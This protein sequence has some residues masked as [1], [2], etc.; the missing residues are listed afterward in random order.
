MTSTPRWW[1]LLVFTSPV[2]FAFS[3][4]AAEWTVADGF[5]VTE[6]AVPGL[7]RHPMMA[8]VDDTGRL[9]V[10]ES[11]GDNLKPEEIEKDPPH[12]IRLLTDSNGDGIYDEATTFVDALNF[13][14]GS[15]W[16]YDSLYVMSPPSLWRF[17]D[18]DGDGIAEIR[19][20]LVTG[21]DYTGNAADVHGP[22]LHPNGRLYW[23]HG[24][25][26]HE[27]YDP[28]TGEL[29]SRAKGARIWS[30][31]LDGGDVRVH[32]GGGMDNPVEV[33]FTENGDIVGSINLLYGRPRGDALVH[34]LHGGAYPR[35][36]QQSVVAEFRR[37][38]DLLTEFHN[39]GH[40]A[41]SGMCRY[42]SGVLDPAW[43]D[44]W[45]VSHFNTSTV[46]RTKTRTMGASYEA[47]ETETIFALH[48]PDSHL[49][50]VLEDRNGDLLA[51]DTGGWFRIGCPTSQ[52]AKPEVAGGIYRISRKDE[53]GKVE[54]P[55]IPWPTLSAEAVATRLDSEQPWQRDRAMTELAVR[56]HAALPELRRILRD[57][58]SSVTARRNAIFT[59]ARMKF[60]ASPDL[61]QEA[62]TDP[63]ASVRHAAANAIAVTRS[64]QAVAANQPAERLIEIERNNTIAGALIAMVREGEP[65]TCA[66]A[67]VAL[68]VMANNRACGAL[69]AAAGRALDDRALHHALTYALIEIDDYDAT[70][71]GLS[72]REPG[73][74]L[75]ALWALDQMNASRLEF[76]DLRPFLESPQPAVRD[77]ARTIIATHPEWD[78]AVANLFFS[79]GDS[80]DSTRRDM[81]FDLTPSFAQSPPLRDYLTSLLNGEAVGERLLAFE[82]I[83]A[84]DRI[85]FAPAW[86][87]AFRASLD[88]P[89]PEPALDALAKAPTPRFGEELRRLAS[90]ESLPAWLR[91][92]AMR[93]DEGNGGRLTD[94]LFALLVQ[95][96][97][98][99]EEY[100]T[101]AEVLTIL[102]DARLDRN[103]RTE[104][105]ALAEALGPLELPRLVG[106]F[107][108]VE[109]DEQAQIFA[110][111]LILSPG[112]RNVDP[113]TVRQRFTGYET[114]LEESGLGGELAAIEA[115]FDQRAERIAAL[116]ARLS[117][118]D[119]A[120]GREVF[121]AGKGTCIV[122]HEVGDLGRDIGPNLTTI[123]RIRTGEDLLESIL[124]PGASLARDFETHSIR[125]RDESP[126]LT[127]LVR[128]ESPQ[129][130]LLVDPAGQEHYLARERIA[131][132]STLPISLMPAGLEHTL[133]EKE[134]LDLIAFLK[135]LQ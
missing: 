51:I 10:A 86:E 84:C 26:G 24:R 31:E 2:L 47:V 53:A 21:F 99:E 123:G 101:R 106:L 78:A 20:E 7:V 61:I 95:T 38:G 75:A 35:H 60:S 134:L 63:D 17:A 44:Q 71:S 93:L 6:A 27:V 127:G 80:I 16:V 56:G 45:I 29:V 25:K 87:P 135:S 28:D 5:T 36:D 52:I 48:K 68:G 42:R 119:P 74:V 104:I 126:D 90:D 58:T 77:A 85:E 89:S 33:D 112:L 115:E 120:R 46:T 108:R 132:I 107:R 54:V 72:S 113:R 124:Y 23:C 50:D 1:S 32:A 117:E 30:C 65:R 111:A 94:D 88:G 128:E 73:T 82:L 55:A 97:R 96:L 40:V 91:L 34:W 110:E 118:G 49:T 81:L 43:R 129:H 131:A 83:A 100:R 59:L 41:V 98:D 64:W 37:T 114:A 121:A 133:S 13:P 18:R 12:S 79:W 109:D 130:V 69:L 125:F 19:Q 9:F 102:E 122:C 67:A 39:F 8:T 116:S 15:L 4:H 92:K 14:Q 76:L 103:R 3:S 22:F 57:E 105:A 62:L 66:Q 11:S 70:L